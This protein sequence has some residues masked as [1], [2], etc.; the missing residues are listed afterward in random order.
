MGLSSDHHLF[1]ESSDS[2]KQ[3]QVPNEALLKNA[4]VGNPLKNLVRMFSHVSYPHPLTIVA[5]V[6]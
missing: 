6:D 4:S 1:F 3:M 5:M 2:S